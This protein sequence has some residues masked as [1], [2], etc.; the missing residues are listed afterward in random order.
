MSW[1]TDDDRKSELAEKIC[2]ALKVHAQIEEEIF[3]PQARKATKDND[4]LDEAVVEHAT[5]EKPD[6]RDR[7]HGGRRRTVRRQDPG[8][9]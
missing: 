9:R 2:S 8:S 5:V 6:C 3:Y 1:K 4:L 7:S